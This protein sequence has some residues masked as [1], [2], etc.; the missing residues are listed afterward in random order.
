MNKP[1]AQRDILT[2]FFMLFDEFV[3]EGR[4]SEPSPASAPAPAEDQG[5]DGAAKPKPE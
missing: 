5:T 3:L 4:G 1:K 2:A